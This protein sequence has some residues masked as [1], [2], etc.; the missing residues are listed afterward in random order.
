LRIHDEYFGVLAAATAED[1]E[2]LLAGGDI[3]LVP[4]LGAPLVLAAG[5]SAGATLPEPAI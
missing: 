1:L 2:L 5:D 4:P 3:V